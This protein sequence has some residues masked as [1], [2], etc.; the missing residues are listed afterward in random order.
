[1]AHSLF[2]RKE[3]DSVVTTTEL[4]ILY[5]MVNDRKID[6]CHALAGKLRDVIAKVTEAIKV[7]GLVTTIAKYLNF[8]IENMPFEKIK[9]RH[10]IDTSMMEAMGFG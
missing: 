2:P 7:G 1:M 6:V 3:R 9:G 8:G 5:C 10:F 4:N